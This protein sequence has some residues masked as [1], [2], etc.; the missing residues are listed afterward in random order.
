MNKNPFEIIGSNQVEA[1]I[2]S[3]NI[4]EKDKTLPLKQRIEALI[5]SSPVFLFMKGVPEYPMCGFSSNVV[6]ILDHLKID[7][8]SFDILSDM[9]IRQGVK[10]F[11][12]WP[13]Y[14]QLYVKGELIGGNDIITELYENGELEATLKK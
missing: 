13:T 2:S 3:K 12:N 8:K 10:D 11:A 7:Y 4:Q 6:A 1:K 5:Q 14:P 9:E